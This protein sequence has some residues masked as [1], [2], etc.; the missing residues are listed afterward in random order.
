MAGFE[1]STE[2]VPAVHTGHPQVQ[3]DHGGTEAALEQVERFETVGCD[4]GT[5][6]LVFQ[7]VDD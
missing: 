4:N 1:V 2:E 5:K 6:S 3:Q 7:N